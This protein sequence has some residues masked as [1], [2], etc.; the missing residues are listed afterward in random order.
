MVIDSKHEDIKGMLISEFSSELIR[1]YYGEDLLGNEIGA[2]SKNVVGIAAGALDGL[3]ISSM[4]GALMSRGAREISRLISA[5]GGNE[6]SAYGLCHLGDYEATIFSKYSHNR[7]FGEMLVKGEK[8]TELAEGCYTVI[9]IMHL[10]K[11]YDVDMPVC[12]AVYD[13]IYNGVDPLEAIKKIFDRS[14]KAEFK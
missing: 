9:A 14:I 13:V 7:M 1:F 11:K 4:K 8:Y 5:M 3:H 10:A 2:A 12:S 6:L